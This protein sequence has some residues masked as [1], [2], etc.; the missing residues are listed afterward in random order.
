[1]RVHDRQAFPVTIS[2]FLIISSKV[3]EK[4]EKDYNMIRR[5]GAR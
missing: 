4:D 1:M 5:L 3:D 2:S